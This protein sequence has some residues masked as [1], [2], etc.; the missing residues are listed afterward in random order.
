MSTFH[1]RLKGKNLPPLAEEKVKKMLTLGQLDSTC[2]VSEDRVNWVEMGQHAAFASYCRPVSAPAAPTPGARAPVKGATPAAQPGQARPQAGEEAPI[3]PGPPARFVIPPKWRIGIG[4]AVAIVF[5]VVV[6]SLFCRETPSVEDVIK[7]ELQPGLE[8]H[9]QDIFLN[10]HPVGNAIGVTIEDVKV[11]AWK[12]GRPT[13]RKADIRQ[14]AVKFTLHWTSPLHNN[15]GY[16]TIEYTIDAEKNRCINEKIL[17]TNGTT[18]EEATE[19][20]VKLGYIL[21]S[22][23]AL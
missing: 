3:T 12:N 15:N 6:I 1:L 21:G 17:S 16:T 20:A 8:Q 13:N 18:N 14:Y 22:L 19:I 7:T 10:I 23:L 4:A 5:L 11:T 2:Q 9:Q